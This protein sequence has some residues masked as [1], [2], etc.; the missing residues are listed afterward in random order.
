MVLTIRASV[1]FLPSGVINVLGTAILL[2]SLQVY[3]NY[4]V[5]LIN[6]SIL[7]L[8]LQIFSEAVSSY[9]T[10]RLHPPIILGLCLHNLFW[11]F[12]LIGYFETLS[13]D[14]SLRLPPHHCYVILLRLC[15]SVW[16]FGPRCGRHMLLLFVLHMWFFAFD[17]NFLFFNCVIHYFGLQVHAARLILSLVFVGSQ[18]LIC[19]DIIVPCLLWGVKRL[20]LPSPHLIIT[21]N[22]VVLLRNLML[23]QF[24]LEILMDWL[25]V[26][27]LLINGSTF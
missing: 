3:N 13:L 5:L 14:F 16:G 18:V 22:F 19:V 24:V 8:H 2:I 6:Y 4:K 27:A 9:F 21:F 12:V 23:I 11:G 17:A 15:S 25:M 7:K 1:I 20:T 26:Y 10:L